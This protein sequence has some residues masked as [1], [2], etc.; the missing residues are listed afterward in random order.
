MINGRIDRNF[1]L[2]TSDISPYDIQDKRRIQSMVEQDKQEAR[3]SENIITTLE[4]LVLRSKS[5]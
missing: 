4:S 1:N 5:K 3:I 2:I